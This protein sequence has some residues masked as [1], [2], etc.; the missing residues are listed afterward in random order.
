MLRA[1]REI[2]LVVIAS[3]LKSS[4]TASV[5]S[6]QLDITA[7]TSNMDSLNLEESESATC[8]RLTTR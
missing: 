6:I 7:E 1:F 4:P 5:Q 8:I 3:T 2:V